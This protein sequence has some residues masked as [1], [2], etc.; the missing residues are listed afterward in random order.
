MFTKEQLQGILLSLPKCEIHINQ[1]N[2]IDIGYRVRLRINFRAS[3]SDFLLALQRT[4]TQYEIKS[5]FKEMEHKSR[6]KPILRVSGHKDVY[7]LSKLI[8]DLPDAKNEWKKNLE[9][10]DIVSSGQHLELPGLERI[11]ELKEVLG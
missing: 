7:L 3:S 9:I 6:P 1:A 4:L 10:I 8:P 11:F 2:N 5:T